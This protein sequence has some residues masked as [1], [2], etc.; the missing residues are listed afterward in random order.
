MGGTGQGQETPEAVKVLLGEEL[1][2]LHVTDSVTLSLEEP[3]EELHGDMLRQEW[4]ERRP[5]S[6]RLHD[7]RM[8]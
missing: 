2:V 6:A 7:T 4:G 8:A 1:L 5:P 3:L